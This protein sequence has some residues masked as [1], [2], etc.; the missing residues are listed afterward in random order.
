MLNLLE[1]LISFAV[2][3]LGMSLI[4]T[5]L[6]QAIS[7]FLGSRGG[8]LEWTL[9]NLLRTLRPEL[10]EKLERDGPDLAR[11]LTKHIL[12]HPLICDS[13]Y[14][15]EGLFI[16]RV[17]RR[18]VEVANSRWKT[19]GSIV[20]FLRRHW[21]QT[22]PFQRRWARA[23]TIRFE[24]LIRVLDLI[25]DG[26]RPAGPPSKAWTE[27][28]T[29]GWLSGDPRLNREWFDTAMDRA[30]QRFVTHMRHITF[31]CS[32]VLAFGSHFDAVRLYRQ[33]SGNA[34]LRASVGARA[35][36]MMARYEQ[37]ISPEAIQKGQAREVNDRLK[38]ARA[39]ADEIRTELADAGI[40]LLPTPYDKHLRVD[41][42][43]NPWSY[44]WVKSTASFVGLDLVDGPGCHDFL[45]WIDFG[46]FIGI[47]VS[48]ILLSLGAPFWYNQLR[49]LTSLKP[50][51]AQKDEKE[52]EVAAKD[53]TVT[54][55]EK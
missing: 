50:V 46:H 49:F 25:A 40:E 10:K 44:S 8:N 33:L 54:F 55:V 37:S 6:T 38:I 43:F 21:N 19:L 2:V 41:G 3:L 4:L 18:I 1:T 27:Q 52:R 30:S 29:A 32:V 13:A 39:Q 7:G 36:A 11:R 42:C 9:A 23:T 22:A 47:L 45:P 34:D 24:E 16:L 15:G 28:E 53:E 48:C 26:T 35:E 17:G 20:G 31:V 5:A 51:I 14:Q 12:Q